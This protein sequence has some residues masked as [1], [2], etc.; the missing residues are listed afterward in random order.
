MPKRPPKCWWDRMIKKIA[1]TYPTRS[2]KS[3]RKIVGGIWVDYSD[4]AKKKNVDK[5]ELNKHG[6]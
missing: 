2:E 6:K 3:Q 1:K 5:C 4:S